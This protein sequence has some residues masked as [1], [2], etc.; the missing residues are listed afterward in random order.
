MMDEV[1]SKEKREEKNKEDQDDEKPFRDN[2]L[3]GGEDF[4]CSIGCKTCGM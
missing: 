2:N 4:V 1:I 3:K